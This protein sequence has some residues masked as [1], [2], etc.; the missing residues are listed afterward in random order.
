M[1]ITNVGE[2]TAFAQRAVEMRCSAPYAFEAAKQTIATSAASAGER[3]CRAV[4]KRAT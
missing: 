2:L 1:R 4:G 3:F